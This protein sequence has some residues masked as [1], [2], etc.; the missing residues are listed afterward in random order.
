MTVPLDDGGSPAMYHVGLVVGDLA[1]AVDQDQE[2]LDLSFAKVREIH[3]P[4]VVD[5]ERR[6]IDM[7]AT[8]SLDGPPYLEL[9]EEKAGATLAAD[10][11]GLN[12]LG[13]WAKDVPAAKARLDA[14]GMPGRVRDQSVPTRI[15]YHQSPHGL[16]IELVDTS[17]KATLDDWLAT[18]Y[19][20]IN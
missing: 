16:W 2:A 19:E 18:P 9:I 10:A 14:L 12:H 8:Y 4:V 13:F 1:D 17:V 3:F 15:S 11:L 6:A 20:R 7:L 5:G